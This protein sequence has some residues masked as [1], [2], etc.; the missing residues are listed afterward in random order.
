MVTTN[1]ENGAYADERQDKFYKLEDGSWWYKYRIEVFKHITEKYFDQNKV[2]VDIGGSNGFNAIKMQDEGWDMVLVEPTAKACE[3][4]KKRGVKKIVNK[5]FEEYENELEQWFLLDVIELIRDDEK[6]LRNLY[7][8]TEKG[9]VG[10]IAAIAS[11]ALWNSEDEVDGHYRRYNKKT[12]T[13]LVE[14][15]GFE[16][17]YINYMYQFLWLP[18]FLLRRMREKLPFVHKVYE[19]TPEEDNKWDHRQFDEPS[20]LIG[21]ILDIFEKR[22]QKRIVSGKQIPYGSTIVCIVKKK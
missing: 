18:H 11:M 20:G 22:E 3:N 19:R 2:I 9:G 14:K 6:M 17:M 7:D 13:E 21:V 8:R 5:P 1:Q 16:I 12:M 15:A 10:L 4:A